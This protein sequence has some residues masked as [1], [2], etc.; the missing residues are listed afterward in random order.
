MPRKCPTGKYLSK[1]TGKCERR[2]GRPSYSPWGEIDDLHKYEEGVFNV[3]TPSHGGVMIHE[4]IAPYILSKEAIKRAERYGK[5]LAYEEDCEA[6]IPLYEMPEHWEK[7][8]DNGS[9]LFKSLSAWDADY[10]LERGIEPEEE[11]HNRYKE[12]RLSDEMRTGKHPDLIVAAYGDWHTGKKGTVLVVTA[13]GDYYDV[14]QESYDRRSGIN[15]LSK[16]E[17]INSYG[18]QDPYGVYEKQLR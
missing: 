1:R 5:W 3:G 4:E 13:S 6:A 2:L 15:R 9:S 10:L 11:S 7:L 12:M 14:T 8:S 17:I 18:K 16:T